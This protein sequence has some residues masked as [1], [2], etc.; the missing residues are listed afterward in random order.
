MRHVSMCELVMAN[1]TPR[2][3]ALAGIVA[4]VHILAEKMP[5]EASAPILAITAPILDRVLGRKQFQPGDLSRIELIGTLAKMRV[6]LM[7]TYPN[8]Q[9]I[10]T[11]E[12][13]CDAV[14][15]AVERHLRDVR[16]DLPCPGEFDASRRWAQDVAEEGYDQR[17]R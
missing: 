11:T 7:P 9:D 14:E 3:A 6:P 2:E 1:L 10:D 16:K 13:Y 15:E 5:V 4:E 12:A 17:G 8:E